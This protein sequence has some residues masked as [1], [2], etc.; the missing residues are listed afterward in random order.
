MPTPVRPRPERGFYLAT[1]ERQQK[2][3]AKRSWVAL[4]PRDEEQ[5]LTPGHFVD[6]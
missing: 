4:V 2:Q 6:P 3:T 5:Q 1:R